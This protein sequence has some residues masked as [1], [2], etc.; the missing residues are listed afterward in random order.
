MQPT[1]ILLSPTPPQLARLHRI[2]A[3]FEAHCATVREIA[4][5]HHTRHQAALHA[6]SYSLLCPPRDQDGLPTQY[7][8]RAI[9]RVSHQLRAEARGLPDPYPDHSFDLDAHCAALEPHLK[10]LA[11]ST[12]DGRALRGVAA[13][14]ARLR[15]PASL[16]KDITLHSNPHLAGAT[17]VLPPKGRPFLLA[18][19]SLHPDP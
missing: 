14:I 2:L 4:A 19:Y 1:R 12:P 3:A 10:A 9:S 17:V 6:L 7:A 16:P 11:L 15:V 8:I 13:Q 5:K 18:R